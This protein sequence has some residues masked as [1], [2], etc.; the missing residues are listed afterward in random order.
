MLPLDPEIV[1]GPVV[2]DPARP[3][4]RPRAL[5]VS[6]NR[7]R[8]PQPC[9]PNGPAAVAAS[10]VRSGWAV[11]A[12]D[13]CFVREPDRALRE[14]IRSERPDAVAFSV[15]NLDNSDLVA[16]EHYVPAARRLVAVARG[17]TTVPLV[18]GGAAFGVA[19]AG[20]V[21]ALDLDAGVAGDGELVAPRV[22]EAAAGGRA[23]IELPGVAWRGASRITPPAPPADLDALPAPEPWRWAD[24]RRYQRH[25]ATVPVQTKRGCVFGCVYCTYLNVEGKGYRLRSP[26]AVVDEVRA[27]SRHGVRRVDFVDS[28]FNSP[29]H[30]A[31]AVAEAL[32]R[33]HT[34]VSLDTT[35]FTP[36]V[37]S[38]ELFAAMRRAG[39]RWLGIT[40]ESASDPVLDQL[41]KGFDVA[42]L[43]ACAA[44]AEAAGIRVLWI[45]LAGGPGE[46]PDTLDETLRFAAGR[47]A[48]G[49]AA[50]L[51]VGLRVYPGTVLQSIAEAE[52]Q[53]APGDPLL[54]PRF[55][56]SPALPL[57]RALERL[58]E[59]A[60][61]EPR[62][63]F[64][65]DS[66]NPAMP[67]LV[68]LASLLG[69]PRPHWRYLSLFRRLAGA[70]A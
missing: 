2:T 59:F 22:L 18:G 11:S 27:L 60:A 9:V 12:L 69:L 26:A 39:F 64:S 19:P 15:R 3:G 67:R 35:N 14:A 24:L 28:T 57:E 70:R 5:L 33:V 30:H 21:S 40:A 58:R 20:L 31:V 44:R 66:R 65:A 52:G 4:T 36:A 25:G 34:G 62:F 38:P 51:T 10:L 1:T 43:H 17:E 8:S 63:M 54:A 48:R 53:V 61:R 16:T 42:R 32:A 46:T 45:F 47:L 50:Y 55:Y 56:L 49:D 6:T 13:L 68:R 23:G 37:A 41:R 29:L 7:E